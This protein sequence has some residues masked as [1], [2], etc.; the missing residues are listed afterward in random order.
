MLEKLILGI[1]FKE[2][3]KQLYENNKKQIDN[4]NNKV[5][6]VSMELM[7]HKP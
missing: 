6:R 7:R 2:E 3:D 4:I 1:D 5:K